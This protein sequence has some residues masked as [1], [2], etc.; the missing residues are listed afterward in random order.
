MSTAQYALLFLAVQTVSAVYVV[1]AAYAYY[2]RAGHKYLLDQSV[3]ETLGLNIS[4]DGGGVL[5]VGY[6]PA[7]DPL[8]AYAFC[9]NFATSVGAYGLMLLLGWRMHC[10]VRENMRGASSTQ[11]RVLEL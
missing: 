6:S 2:P 1:A 9:Y 3:A 10:F 11:K 7:G 5:L 4:S 8:M